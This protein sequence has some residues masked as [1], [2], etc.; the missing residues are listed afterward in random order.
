MVLELD[1]YILYMY[2]I[3][4]YMYGLSV[5][6]S[7]SLIAYIDDDLILNFST[8]GKVGFPLSSFP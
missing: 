1:R 6:L 5:S 3:I 8:F 2:G 7:I 4:D